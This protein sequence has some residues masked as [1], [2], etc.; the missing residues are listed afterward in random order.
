ML[1][2]LKTE[3]AWLEKTAVGC[4]QGSSSPSFLLSLS[5]PYEIYELNPLLSG[6]L[7]FPSLPTSPNSQTFNTSS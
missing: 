1:T 7:V 4:H 2:K 3:Q 5:L 6:K